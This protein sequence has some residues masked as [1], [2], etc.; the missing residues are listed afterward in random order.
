MWKV[1]EQF[2]PVV[3][4][5]IKWAN[6]CKV[7]STVYNT[8]VSAWH[9]KFLVAE[10]SS[11]RDIH[12]EYTYCQVDGSAITET[13]RSGIRLLKVTIYEGPF[14]RKPWVTYIT[15]WVTCF[16]LPAPQFLVV[17]FK[18]VNKGWIC[19]TLDTQPSML[20]KARSPG[21]L[22]LSLSPC[23]LAKWPLR[24]AVYSRT[25][26][27]NSYSSKFPAGVSWWLIG[28]E[29]AHQ[30]RRHGFDSWSGK[31]PH[32]SEQLSPCIT[33]TAPAL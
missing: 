15:A 1:E 31:I 24:C 22:Y 27:N 29:S 10:S 14:S 18:L 19:E 6:T 12:P 23:N 26:S 5:R 4:M 3:A 17:C 20:M 30:C 13:T 11:S 21:L 7:L 25:W 33:T 9:F 28:K 32:A 2:P 16:S 8:R